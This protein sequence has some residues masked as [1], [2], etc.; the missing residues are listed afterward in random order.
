MLA[1]AFGC[2]WHSRPASPAARRTG[3][4]FAVCAHTRHPVT[5][6]HIASAHHA[7]PSAAPACAG[8]D[9]APEAM[10]LA[11]AIPVVPT[12]SRSRRATST[13]PASSSQARARGGQT[14]WRGGSMTLAISPFGGNRSW[15]FAIGRRVAFWALG[16]R[17]KRRQRSERPCVAG[18]GA[19]PC[20][21]GGLEW[22]Q[23]THP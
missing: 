6:R 12:T 18:A 17:A 19:L 15:R 10:R 14:P 21:E 1:R 13:R 9:A 8:R 16:R 4:F 5:S 11:Q 3:C 20:S 22:H 7:P 23:H 2:C